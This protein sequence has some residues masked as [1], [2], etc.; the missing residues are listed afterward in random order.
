[1]RRQVDETG[2]PAAFLFGGETTVTVRGDGLGGRNT[3]LAL[4]TAREIDGMRGVLAAFVATDGND[5]PTDA[6]GAIVTGETVVRAAA[7]G[8]GATEFL[9]RNDSYHFFASTG[10][11]LKTG[12]TNTNVNDIG[13]ALVW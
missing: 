6:A 8:C 3:E 12:A 13:M 1:L 5:G 11:L 10:N 2:A 4:A 7:Q 9:Q